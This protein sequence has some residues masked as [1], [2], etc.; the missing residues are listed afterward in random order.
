MGFVESK[1]NME[2]MCG[3]CKPQCNVSKADRSV[4]IAFLNYHL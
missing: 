1:K 2:E 3:S 4:S